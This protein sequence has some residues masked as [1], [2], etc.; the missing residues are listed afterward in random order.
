MIKIAIC[1]D[2][3]TEID[4]LY[5]EIMKA[6]DE[7]KIVVSCDKLLYGNIL[8]DHIQNRKTVYDIIFLDIY[9]PDITG[10]N[11]AKNIK[12]FSPK[13]EIV[14]VTLSR[15]HAVEAFDLHALHYIIKPV[16]VQQIKDVFIRYDNKYKVKKTIEVR[17]GR[18]LIQLDLKAV[19]YLESHNNG[20]DIYT[21]SGKIHTSINTRKLEEQLDKTFL[22]IQR[23][24]IVN[25]HF[26]DHMTTDSCILKNRTTILISRKERSNIR[27]TYR[28]FIFN[29]LEEGE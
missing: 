9:M 23:G 20:T 12:E 15:Q 3:K 6:A 26:V 16:N 24:F 11:L 14:F 8:L 13:T 19:Q 4:L 7:A 25:M 10:L 27:A 29:S 28:E 5:K 18:D 21:K 1:D 2:E 17:V 22:R